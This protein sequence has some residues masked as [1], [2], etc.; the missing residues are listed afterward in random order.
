[1][2]QPQQQQSD[3]TKPTG[4]DI[5]VQVRGANK[6]LSPTCDR[7]R[8]WMDENVQVADDRKLGDMRIVSDEALPGILEK[9]AADQINVKQ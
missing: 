4:T 3:P 2:S 9:A 1:M 8:K 6:I 5:Y 7:A